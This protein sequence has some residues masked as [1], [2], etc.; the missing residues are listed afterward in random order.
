MEARQGRDNGEHRRAWFTTAG[1]VGHVIDRPKCEL[2]ILDFKLHLSELW[3]EMK[4]TG[5]PGSR[6]K[7]GF[8]EISDEK[9]VCYEHT[10]KRRLPLLGGI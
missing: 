7:G 1:P 2:S 10:L 3:C 8:S 4:P 9:S 6:K 5:L